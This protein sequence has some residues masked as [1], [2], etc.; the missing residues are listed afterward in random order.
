MSDKIRKLWIDNL[1]NE[2]TL[3]ECGIC[4]I[5]CSYIALLLLNHVETENT[6]VAKLRLQLVSPSTQYNLQRLGC[7]LRGIT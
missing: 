7:S 1:V 3:K 5:H 6:F 2:I 4:S